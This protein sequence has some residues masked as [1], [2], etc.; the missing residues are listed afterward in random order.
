MIRANYGACTHV[1]Q[2]RHDNEDAYVA[3]D[4]L[5][6][7]ADGMGGHSAGE[8]ASALTVAT[9]KEKFLRN[10]PV[11]ENTA[12]RD[13]AGRDTGDS[14]A[15]GKDIADRNSA[16]NVSESVDGNT[17]GTHSANNERSAKPGLR[18]PEQVAEAIALANTAVFIESTDDSSKSGMGTTLTGVVVTEP[19][20]NTIVVANV[21]DSRTYLWR[22]GELR[23]ITKDHSH[24]QTLVDRG[25]ITPA[26][27]R[28][29]YQRNIV[30]RAI[31]I[32]AE[33]HVDLFPLTVENGDR[34]IMCSDGL[35]DEA[36]DEEIINEIRLEEKP[37]ELAER[38]VQLANDNGGR[39]N[40]TVIV[41]DFEIVESQDIENQDIENQNIENQ[42]TE[43]RDT[44]IYNTKTLEIETQDTKITTT[45]A[46]AHGSTTGKSHRAWSRSLFRARR[47]PVVAIVAALVIVIA[48]IVAVISSL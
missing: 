14:D 45:T 47:K 32:E 3:I 29:H 42:E 35:V 6:L 25:A 44:E 27:A 43:S 40:V 13:T 23:Q 22:N 8:V 48:V 46:T 38:L 26:E 5:Y 39:D 12:G 37:Q 20:N 1:G 34:F 41:V 28:V 7:V 9:L 15:A 33:V 4:G 2:V 24:V 18:T 19:E 30:L 31:G 21:G 17:A 16:D 10:A 11:A 36:D